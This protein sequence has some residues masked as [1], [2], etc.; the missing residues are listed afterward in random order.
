M[1]EK[2]HLSC[3]VD[4]G[5]CVHSAPQ[6]GEMDGEIAA[7]MPA[8]GMGGTDCPESGGSLPEERR[9]RKITSPPMWLKPNYAGASQKFICLRTEQKKYVTNLRSGF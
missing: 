5:G 8:N 9:R 2:C 3:G 7:G 4:W 6:H 1:R